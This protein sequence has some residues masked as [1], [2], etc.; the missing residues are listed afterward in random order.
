MAGRQPG[1]AL[2]HTNSSPE[3]PPQQEKESTVWGGKVNL[4]EFFKKAKH[5]VV[6]KKDKH[7]CMWV[8]SQSGNGP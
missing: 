6:T 2:S 4:F 5:I 1:L 8:V 3:A 7:F